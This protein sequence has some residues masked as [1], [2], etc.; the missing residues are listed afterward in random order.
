MSTGAVELLG[1]PIKQ[2][3]FRIDKHDTV[4]TEDWVQ[5]YVNTKGPKDK[6]KFECNC[7]DTVLMFTSFPH[8]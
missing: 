8:R 4:I 6:G 1:E 3:G 5:L 7:V 2:L